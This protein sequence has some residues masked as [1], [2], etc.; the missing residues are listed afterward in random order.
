MLISGGMSTSDIQPR[1]IFPNQ[2]KPY[3]MCPIFNQH[4][5]IDSNL[6]KWPQGQLKVH[7]ESL[8]QRTQ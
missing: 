5:H 2:A 3:P 8:I 6:A 1:H 7:K 4:D